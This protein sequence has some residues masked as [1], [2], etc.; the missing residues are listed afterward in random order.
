MYPL[1]SIVFYVCK[2]PKGVSLMRGEFMGGVPALPA[3]FTGPT[4]GVPRL[5]GPTAKD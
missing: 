5:Q 2:G 1:V 4:V 3:I